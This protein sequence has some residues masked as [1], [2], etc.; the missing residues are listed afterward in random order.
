MHTQRD[1]QS[2]ETAPKDGTRVLL[3]NR[4]PGIWI[5]SFRESEQGWPMYE[6]GGMTGTWWPTPTAWMPLPG[7]PE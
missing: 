5:S 4:M 1:W 6:W 7:D 3:Y 2:M